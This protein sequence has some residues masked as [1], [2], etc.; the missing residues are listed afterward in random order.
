MG[1]HL[2]IEAAKRPHLLRPLLRQRAAPSPPAGGS[3]ACF[4]AIQVMV[5]IS[6][7]LPTSLMRGE[8]FRDERGAGARQADDEDRGWARRAVKALT[9]GRWCLPG[10]PRCAHPRCAPVPARAGWRG[11]AAWPSIQLRKASSWRPLCS[12]RLPLRSMQVASGEG[13]KAGPRE[14]PLDQAEDARGGI[15]LADLRE[16]D[17]VAA[18]E[19]RGVDAA[20]GSPLSAS[21]A[22][23]R[24]SRHSTLSRWMRWASCAGADASAASKAASASSP[25]PMPRR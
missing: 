16:Q 4:A 9:G 21:S 14:F 12:S 13:G 2:A 17:D 11:A 7:A 22:R 25:R 20:R 10:R 3:P 5:S 18:A 24:E 15:G 8:D 23:P 19:G 6:P 1:R